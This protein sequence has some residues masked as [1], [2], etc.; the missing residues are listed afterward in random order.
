[1]FS[2]SR[3]V[4]IAAV[5]VGAVIVSGVGAIGFHSY[6]TAQSQAKA[7]MQNSIGTGYEELASLVE[8]QGALA[9]AIG[10]A[11]QILNDSEGATLDEVA[12]E[13]LNCEGPNGLAS[14][15]RERPTVRGH[16]R[17]CG[18]EPVRRFR[19]ASG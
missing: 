9:L 10:N 6:A 5:T 19:V 4:V 2:L 16:P 12:R 7:E 1:M 13:K 3:R 17:S 14:T 15:A 8:Q 11:E 18:T